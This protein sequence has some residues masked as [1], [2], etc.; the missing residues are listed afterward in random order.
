[1][2]TAPSGGSQIT[3]R[4]VKLSEGQSLPGSR[5]PVLYSVVDGDCEFSVS[6]GSVQITHTKTPGPQLDAELDKDMK[7]RHGD[8]MFFPNGVRTTSRG[9]NSDDLELLQVIV[10]PTGDERLLEDRR[11]QLKFKQPT[12]PPPPDQDQQGGTDSG[13]QSSQSWSEGDSVYVNSTDVNLR[14]SPSI[15]GGLVTV[16]L[17]GQEMIIDGEPTDADGIIWW[18]VHIADDPTL[19]GYVTQE[20]I[21]SDPVE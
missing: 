4:R 9:E 5:N 3:I 14:D 1:M 2:T 20:F 6:A 10:S 15:N 11:G 12:T 18:P 16:L 13:S 17:Y 21:Q 7:L 19:A 8:A